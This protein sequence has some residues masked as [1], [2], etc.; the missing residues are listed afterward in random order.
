MTEIIGKD[1][2]RQGSEVVLYFVKYS[3]VDSKVS[4]F[5]LRQWASLIES[6]HANSNYV[7][8]VAQSRIIYATMGEKIV[9]HLLW[10][11]HNS[12]SYIVFT[13]VDP[14]FR[15][16]GLYEILHK[17]YD[18]RMISGATTVSRSSLHVNNAAV[19]AAAE[20]NGYEVEFL[21]MRKNY[22]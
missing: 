18:Q 2:D 8:N 9:G 11:W 13:V 17:F 1:T 14:A 20:K 5:F 19:I 4:A 7:P 21:K 3:D 22:K 15:R 16:R 6:G 12:V 10:E